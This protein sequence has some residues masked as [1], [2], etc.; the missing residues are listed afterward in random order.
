MQQA[1]GLHSTLIHRHFSAN[2]IGPDGRKLYT[3]IAVDGGGAVPVHFHKA[4]TA[5]ADKCFQWFITHCREPQRL[6]QGQNERY[7]VSQ[8]LVF[9]ASS[10]AIGDNRRPFFERPL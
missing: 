1:K 2:K 10:P 6:S 3:Q 9:D 8:I 7:G 5:L 4:E